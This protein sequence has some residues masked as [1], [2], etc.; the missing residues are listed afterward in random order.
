M[1]KAPLKFLERL[2]ATPSPSGFEAAAQR[3]WADYVSPCCDERSSDSYGNAFARLGDAD[4]GPHIVLA[5]HIDEL[6]FM[7][8]HINDEGFLFVQGIGGIDR[9]LFRGQRVHVHGRK[10]SVPGV[11]GSLAIHLQEPDDRKKVPE[12]HEMYVDIGAS[13]KE[14]AGS[15]CGWGC[16]HLC[17]RLRGAGK[18]PRRRA[19]L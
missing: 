13:S 7:V 6:G 4:K 18:R 19:R 8:S 3:V 17:G 14:E 16:H 12:L 10:G 15:M 5:G 9:A 11:T 1:Q 2:I